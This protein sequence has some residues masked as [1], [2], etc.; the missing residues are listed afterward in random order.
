MGSF[1]NLYLDETKYNKDGRFMY[2]IAGMAIS[3][4]KVKNMGRMLGQLKKDLW[5]E[6]KYGDAKN[7]VFH[8][9]DIRSANTKFDSNYSIFQIRNNKRKA[10]EEIGNILKTNNCTVFGAMVDL[11]SIEEK[12]KTKSSYYIGDSICL[13]N[14]VNNF[15]CF[16]KNHKSRGRI[17]FESRYDHKGNH[18]DLLLQK[19]FYKI[20]THGTNIYKPIEIQQVISDIRFKKKNDNDAGL[21]I[22][23]FIP[24]HFMI[25]FC[26]NSQAKINIYKTLK[27]L[28]YSGGLTKGGLHSKDF[29]ICYIK[30]I[31]SVDYK[32]KIL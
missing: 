28:R 27:K 13:M 10:F 5:Q 4:N 6:K 18:A 30:W 23:D 22:A 17:I 11:T 12:Y 8:M 15:V 1:Y 7:I 24:S 9:A 26:G 19:Q 14:I 21:Q 25:N 16:L 32:N 31:K 3:D 20:I 29:G 2:G